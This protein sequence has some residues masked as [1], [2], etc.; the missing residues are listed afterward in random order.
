MNN[1]GYPGNNNINNT[2]TSQTS[3]IPSTNTLA[4]P[5][6]PPPQQNQFGGDGSIANTSTTTTTM[7][8]P[9]T[10]ATVPNPTQR[11]NKNNIDSLIQNYVSQ[12]VNSLPLSFLQ[13]I[14]SQIESRLKKAEKC[15]LSHMIHTVA[16]D[17]GN[18]LLDQFQKTFQEFNERDV[19]EKNDRLFETFC[20]VCVYQKLGLYSDDV[21]KK[22]QG[23]T[24]RSNRSEKA[25]TDFNLGS[26]IHAVNPYK[27]N[28]SSHP[29]LSSTHPSE[30]MAFPPGSV[31][32]PSGKILVQLLA[33]PLEM[34]TRGGLKIIQINSEE[35]GVTNPD[36][37]ARFM[38]RNPKLDCGYYKRTKTEDEIKALNKKPD[39]G[40]NPTDL[41]TSTGIAGS[42][43]A[44]LAGKMVPKLK[45]NVNQV[46][47]QH[48]PSIDANFNF[49]NIFSNGEPTEFV[50]PDQEAQQDE[51]LMKVFDLNPVF[52]AFLQNVINIQSHLQKHKNVNKKSD[53][54][55]DY[56]RPWANV[57]PLVSSTFYDILSLAFMSET[58]PEKLLEVPPLNDKCLFAQQ[59]I[60]V[61][62]KN[63]DCIMSEDTSSDADTTRCTVFNRVLKHPDIPVSQRIVPTATPKNVDIRGNLPSSKN[64]SAEYLKNLQKG[65]SEYDTANKKESLKQKYKDIWDHHQSLSQTYHKSLRINAESIRNYFCSFKDDMNNDVPF[66]DNEIVFD[67][68]INMYPQRITDANPNKQ[69]Y[70]LDFSKKATSRPVIDETNSPNVVYVRNVGFVSIMSICDEAPLVLGNTE[71]NIQNVM[72]KETKNFPEASST[73][74]GYSGL[75]DD[76]GPV[77]SLNKVDIKQIPS[78]RKIDGAV[79]LS[80]GRNDA[81]EGDY[82]KMAKCETQSFSQ[83][84]STYSNSMENKG[85]L[86]NI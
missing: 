43:N 81:F 83:Y 38:A 79:N 73:N 15:S 76:G 19:N 6:P 30:R 52:I 72:K 54:R 29:L 36:V 66:K 85:C 11:D 37:Y 53:H 84:L 32:I 3:F 8:V 16:N 39:A 28:Q 82:T 14:Q 68:A 40:Y 24:C 61:V 65:Y 48:I 22:L 57:P 70:S 55:E 47:L 34:L 60:L 45:A 59:N 21:V 74:C 64:P 12:N 17:A 86:R 44:T 33:L 10:A 62:N 58:N 80:R 75:D 4:A 31:I 51:I 67:V 50:K 9:V 2:N 23:F 49:R 1:F 77:A 20:D 13:G 7:P 26:F 5:P 41:Q 35:I 63:G 27:T 78:K 42:L 18:Y 46:G 69:R 25:G 56:L 71:V